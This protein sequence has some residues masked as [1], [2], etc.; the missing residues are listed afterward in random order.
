[1]PIRCQM[2]DE[3]CCQRK[4]L[5]NS[6]SC[7]NESD[8]LASIEEK[9]QNLESRLAEY[10]LTNVELMEQNDKFRENLSKLIESFPKKYFFKK[11]M[12]NKCSI[13]L[14]EYKY[15]DKIAVTNC[16]HLF[17]KNCIDKSIE[18]N[19]MDCPNCRFK[20]THSVFLYLNFN[21]EMKGTE[22]L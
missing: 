14:E 11:I 18:Q 21:L 19:C 5:G 2:G 20:L 6:C 22:F 16:I 10:E 1:M 9:I 3:F 12:E 8:G 15:G 17:H 13:C 7:E 4:I